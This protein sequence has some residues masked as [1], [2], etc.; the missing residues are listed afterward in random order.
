MSH[1]TCAWDPGALGGADRA[2]VVAELC[3]SDQHRMRTRSLL[4]GLVLRTGDRVLEVGCGSGEVLLEL[5]RRR[6]ADVTLVGVDTDRNALAIA[7]HAARALADISIRRM[8]GRALE[9]ADGHFDL[10][11]FSRVLTHASNPKLLLSEA[12][13]VLRPGGQAVCIEPV[14]A[15]ATGIDDELR[16]RVHG[17][18]HPCIGRDLP[19]LL[20][21]AGLAPRRMALHTFVDSKPRD[22]SELWREFCDG[23]GLHALARRAHHCTAEDFARYLEARQRALDSGCFFESVVH[24][25]IFAEKLDPRSDSPCPHSPPLSSTIYSNGL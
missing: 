23:T 9:F 19:P 21:A 25:G 11:C 18:R 6:P 10:V 22:G 12:S 4:E 17:Q 15:F 16:R 2:K 1:E 8:D 5:S 13:R 24:A 7:Q 20:Q 3:S 14:I